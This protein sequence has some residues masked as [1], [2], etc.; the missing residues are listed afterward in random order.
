MVDPQTP[1]PPL[2]GHKC[3]PLGPHSAQR[4]IFPFNPFKPFSASGAL[5]LRGLQTQ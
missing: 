3:G 4:P 5:D 1:L 2:Q